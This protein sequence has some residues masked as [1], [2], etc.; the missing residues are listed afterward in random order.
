[1]EN[2]VIFNIRAKFVCQT[3][4]GPL[5]N[6]FFTCK[7]LYFVSV[8]VMGGCPNLGHTSFIEYILPYT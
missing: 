3:K 4:I 1:M 5:L 2:S 8:A 6:K 7:N